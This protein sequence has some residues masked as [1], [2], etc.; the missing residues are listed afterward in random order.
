MSDRREQHKRFVDQL[1]EAYPCMDCGQK[2]PAEAMDL[3]HVRGLKRGNISDM[4][5]LSWPELR[6][7]LLKTEPVCSTCHRIRTRNR[8]LDETVDQALDADLEFDLS[9][10]A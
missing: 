1:K 5:H 4:L 6:A 2:F 7:E 3:D 8:R 9:D 10:G